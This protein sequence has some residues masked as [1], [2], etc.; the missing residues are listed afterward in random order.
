MLLFVLVCSSFSS[1]FRLRQVERRLICYLS[2]I[3]AFIVYTFI[4]LLDIHKFLSIILCFVLVQHLT[5]DLVISYLAVYFF[6]SYF[7]LVLTLY[8]CLHRPQIYM[9]AST[10]LSILS[11]DYIYELPASVTHCLKEENEEEFRK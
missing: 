7:E 1:V 8:V 4:L 6:F 5:T 2:L 11:K 10:S 9:S 3:E